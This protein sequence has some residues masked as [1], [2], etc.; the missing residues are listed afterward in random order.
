VV[1]SVDRCELLFFPLF[2]YR[3]RE[4]DDSP[5]AA[6]TFGCNYIDNNFSW[7]IPLIL[8]AFACTI[9]IVAV[10]F[11]PESPRWL[12]ANGRR[13]EAYAF[14]AKYHGGGDM[15]SKLVQLEIAEFEEGIREDGSDKQWWDCE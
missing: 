2:S 13:D 9:I 6:V 3:R 15:N 1:G 10:F 5:A 14:L 7:R 11:I 4:S 8:Q 12:M